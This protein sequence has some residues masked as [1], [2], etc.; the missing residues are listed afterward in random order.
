MKPAPHLLLRTLL[1]PL[2]LALL[3]PRAGAQVLAP[4][5]LLR[6]VTLDVLEVIRQ[7][8]DIQAGNPAK[9]ADLVEMK[10]LPHFDF[11]RMTR[12]AVARNWSLAS[13]SQQAALTAEFKTLLVRTYSTALAAYRNQVSEFRPLRAAPGDEVTVRSVIR[14]SGTA[15]IGMDYDMERLPEGWKV[16]D[17]KIDGMSLV[18]TY[19]E[20][21]ASKVR[22]SGVE[23]LIRT[24]SEKNRQGDARFRSHKTG[25]FYIPALLIHAHVAWQAYISH[26]R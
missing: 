26:S 7:D 8:K 20:T 25:D 5:V 17:I 4:D 19:R 3:V 22:E 23:G 1:I 18:T 16:Y 14:Q 11:P 21:F 9:V 2:V 13:A 10:I 12:I 6:T 15:T 24:L